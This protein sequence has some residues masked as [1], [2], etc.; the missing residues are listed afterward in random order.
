MKI[1]DFDNLDQTFK[2]VNFLHL[3]SLIMQVLLIGLIY[4]FVLQKE[5]FSVNSIETVTYLQ[6]LLIFIAMLTVPGSEYLLK[7]KLKSALQIND[8][9]K[10]LAVYLTFLIFK[11]AIVESINLISIILYFL[12]GSITFFYISVVFV[13]FF[14]MSKP[15]KDK[16]MNDLNL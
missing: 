9:K 14:L 15:G 12:T 10:R 16:T 4:M 8:H 5:N 6:Y 3:I 2:K 11:L 7:Q 13:I 1:I